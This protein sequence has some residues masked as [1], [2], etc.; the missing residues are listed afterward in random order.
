MVHP[1][2]GYMDGKFYR[3]LYFIIR[4]TRDDSFTSR[5]AI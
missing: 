1:L 5:I 3:E 2:R 4:L